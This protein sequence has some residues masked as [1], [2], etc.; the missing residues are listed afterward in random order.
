MK[1][2]SLIIGSGPNIRKIESKPDPRPSFPIGDQEIEMI[3]NTTYLS[4]EIDSQLNSD[5]H[6][7]DIKV[8]G[9]LSP[10]TYQV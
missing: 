10:W 9:K 7:V 4:V 6:T 8:Q 2:Q 1:T 3:R 5:K